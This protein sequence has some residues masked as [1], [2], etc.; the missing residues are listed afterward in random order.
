MM[1][2]TDAIELL[3]RMISMVHPDDLERVRKAGILL[4]EGKKEYMDE[5]FRLI[6]DERVKWLKYTERINSGS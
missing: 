2:K 5:E 1:T 6:T 3:K 4:R